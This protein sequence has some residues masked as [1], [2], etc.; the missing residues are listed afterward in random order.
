MENLTD[1]QLSP[2]RPNP[3]GAHW[4]GTGVNFAVF[5]AHAQAIDLCLFDAAGERELSRQRLPRLTHDVWH[6][7]LAGARPGLVYGL[8]A[9]GPRRPDQGHRFNA[10]KLLLDPYAREIVGNF[11]G[12]GETTDHDNA[13]R[14]L[15][16]RV[17]DAQYDWGDDQ[18]PCTPWADT[19]LYEAHVKGL[20]MRHPGVTPALRGTYAGLA[21]EAVIAHLKRLGITAVNLL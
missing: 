13:A 7:Y 4:N 16:A 5:S 11:E 2:G 10:N 12:Y 19:V 21:S 17:V 9:N 20:T 6:G 18:R 14:A 3:L 1:S 8:R 15:K